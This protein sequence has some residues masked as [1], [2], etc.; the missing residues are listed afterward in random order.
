MLPCQLSEPARRFT[1]VSGI[2]G[3]RTSQDLECLIWCP[4]KTKL[5]QG[6][7]SLAISKSPLVHLQVD[8]MGHIPFVELD[9][10]LASLI[11]HSSCTSALSKKKTLKIYHPSIS[12]HSSVPTAPRWS[13]STL[14]PSP[15]E[16]L[17][18]RRVPSWRGA[19]SRS[20]KQSA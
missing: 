11:Q 13:V 3:I 5:S 4:S 7:S 9:R 8:F 18:K 12:N 17:L 10:P 1:S 15:S 19:S 16:L 14:Q 2:I 6:L 20:S